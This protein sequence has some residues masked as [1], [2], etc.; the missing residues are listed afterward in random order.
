MH[1]RLLTSHFCYQLVFI[2]PDF[3]LYFCI[4]IGGKEGDLFSIN[5]PLKLV[6]EL[7]V[8]LD[9]LSTSACINLLHSFETLHHISLRSFSNLSTDGNFG[10]LKLLLLSQTVLQG[11]SLQFYFCAPVQIVL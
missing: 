6:L 10:Y 8:T 4:Y 7:A 11:T 9:H 5:Y 1:T 2:L 3:P